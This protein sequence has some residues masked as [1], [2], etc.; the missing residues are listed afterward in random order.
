MSN[1]KDK[2]QRRE[3]LKQSLFGGAGLL[4]SSPLQIF[5]ANMISHFLQRGTAFASED[6]AVFFNDFKLIN[7]TMNGGLPRWYW[8]LPMAPNGDSDMLGINAMVISRFKQGTS[9]LTGEYASTKVNDFYL[10]YLWESMI[11]TAGGGMVSMKELAQNMLMIRGIDQQIDSHEIGRIKQI[12][13]VPGGSLMGFIADKARTS[14]PAIDCTGGGQKYYNSKKGIPNIARGGTNPFTTALRPFMTNGQS[15]VSNSGGDI[16]K[17]IDETL[18]VL[19]NHSSAKHSG[20]PMTYENR[21][22]AKK[23]MK[24]NFGDL[25]QAYKD[26]LNKYSSLIS[27]SFGDESLHL[28]DVDDLQIP[29]D[30]KMKFFNFYAEG[31][32]PMRFTGTDIRTLTNSNTTIGNLA[33]S[34]A[35]AEFMI[36]QGH[37][38]ALNLASS[39]LANLSVSRAK[40]ISDDSVFS[41]VSTVATTDMHEVGAYTGLLLN[42]RFYRA[43]SACLNE[44][45]NQLKNTSIGQGQTLFDRCA[46]TVTS[47]FNRSARMDGSGSD[48]GWQGSSYTI[49]SGM[50]PTTTVV[51]NITQFSPGTKYSGMWGLSGSMAEFN[52]RP[53]NIGNVAS[54][55]ATILEFKSPT[56]NDQP[57]VYKKDGKIYPAVGKPKNII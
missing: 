9:G 34:M 25:Q 56:P 38:S 52:N 10:P 50:I 43:Q 14:L 1:D 51:G 21:L 11:P 22:N 31:N 8:D 7:L 45:I 3:F 41:K 6:N 12:V 13:P 32:I 24:K 5:M 44:F 19:S 33:S 23:L 42:T 18:R 48:H 15:I 55:L 28:A 46:V 2:L 57:Y 16:E 36:T 54:T 26:L 35:I 53:G 40:V 30:G 49:L 27:R 37:S 20:I 17:A 4:L 29:G 47:D 39:S